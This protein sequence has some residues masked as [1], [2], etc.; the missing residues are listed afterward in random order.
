M[1]LEEA[2]QLIIGHVAEGVKLA[3]K[4]QLPSKIKAFILTHHAQSKTA[5]F[6]NTLKNNFPNQEIDEAKFTYPGPKPGSKETTI[7]MMADAV[8]ASSRSLKKYDEPTIDELVERIIDGQIANGSFKN[9]PISFRD[10]EVIKAVFK[11]KLKTIYHNR[12]SY[13]ELKSRKK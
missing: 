10:V 7:V 13:P 8:E 2:A 3:D 11:E 9:A 6:Y 5:Y 12:I 1:P 4:Y